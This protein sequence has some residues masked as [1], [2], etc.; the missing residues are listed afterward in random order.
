[1][2]ATLR[3]LLAVCLIAG[4]ATLF[5]QCSSVK[6][7]LGEYNAPAYRP[8]NPNDVRV[9]VSLNSTMVYVME[10]GRALLVTPVAI[11]KPGKE[12][13]RGNFTAYKNVA[14]KFF[15]L[16]KEGTPVNISYTQPEDATLGKNQKR[17]DD[18]VDPDPHRSVMIS[19]AAFPP[20]GPLFESQG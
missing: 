1:M 18:Y 6:T 10:G 8:D 11:G 7:D 12:T 2:V 15:A 14:P 13:P 3:R 16:V 17:P 19:S 4:G 20:E 5:T 9:K